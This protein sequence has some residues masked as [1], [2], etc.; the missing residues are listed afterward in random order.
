M[1]DD[2]EISVFVSVVV[3]RLNFK[4]QFFAFSKGKHL[5]ETV[6]KKNY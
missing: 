6:N 1:P 2:Y 3:G 5:F 4:S